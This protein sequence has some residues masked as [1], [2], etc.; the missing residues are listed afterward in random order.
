MTLFYKNDLPKIFTYAANDVTLERN[1][2]KTM[3]I[4]PTV[5]NPQTLTF[6]HNS[7]SQS[8]TQ[9]QSHHVSKYRTH[10]CAA[11]VETLVLLFIVYVNEFNI[12]H[13]SLLNLHSF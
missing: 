3:L 9:A 2:S 11:H 12:R 8:D 1:Q 5:I 7:N 10:M 13:S 6:K 4:K